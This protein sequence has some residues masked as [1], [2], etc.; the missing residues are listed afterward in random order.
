MRVRTDDVREPAT[1]ATP[2]TRLLGLATFAGLGVL[3]LFA[4][5]L[6]PA[7]QSQGE[8]VRMLYL[9]APTAWVAYLA[10]AVTALASALY[11][12]PRQH[13]LGW[14]RLAGA[15]AEVGVLFMAITLFVGMLWG[16][17]TWGVF[18]RWDARL[19]T[20][21]FLFVT[22]I[23]Y[24]AV[25]RLGGTPDQRARRSGVLALLAVLEIPLVHFS[26]ELWRGLHQDATVLRPD[27]DVELDGLMLFTL[28][29]GIVVFTMLYAWLVI[30][31]QRALTAEDLLDE[32]GLD[33]A[34]AERQQEVAAAAPTERAPASRAVM[35]SGGVAPG[36]EA[37]VS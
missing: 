9:H 23:G 1:T 31:R 27:G 18:W 20:T 29:L 24:L 10:F 15:S 2:A 8:S 4:L 30:H 16:R 32:A 36:D 33:L 25:R 34:I 17:L 28:L 35:G 37:L 22:Y 14:D 19:T 26:V 3:V 6:T 7:D 5:V 11:L 12:F 13:A 21:A